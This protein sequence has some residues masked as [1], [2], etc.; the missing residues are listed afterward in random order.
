MRDQTTISKFLIDT[1]IIIR[2]LRGD[3]RAGF[4]LRHLWTAGSVCSATA[5]VVEVVRG[6][7]NDREEEDSR[8]LFDLIPPVDMTRPIAQ[9][10]G[11][12]IRRNRGIFG[13]DRAA[14]DSMIAA[15]AIHEFAVLV[16]L[17]TR[18]FSRVHHPGLDVLLIDQDS[19]DWVATVS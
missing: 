5:S 1:G 2:E 3:A 7:R 14:A 16:T 19:P 18:Q 15:T 4:L 13:K 9:T 6:C 10:A 8:Q 12:I 11:Q 17:N